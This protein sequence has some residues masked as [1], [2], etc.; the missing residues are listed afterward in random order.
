MQT[1]GGLRII[2]LMAIPRCSVSWVPASAGMTP[3]EAAPHPTNVTPAEAGAQVTG[4]RRCVRLWQEK[5]NKP[6]K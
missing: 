2:P 3:V 5:L 1:Q 6:N 4:P